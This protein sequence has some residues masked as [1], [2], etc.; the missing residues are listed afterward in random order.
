MREKSARLVGIVFFSAVWLLSLVLFKTLGINELISSALAV[1]VLATLVVFERMGKFTKFRAVAL[2]SFLLYG[3]ATLL[4]ISSYFERDSESSLL[5]VLMLACAL[6]LV[7][8]SAFLVL[9][10]VS[11]E[12]RP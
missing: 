12:R 1:G 5:G 6:A 2:P 7:V 11:P 8:S 4:M 9:R 3:S 10:I